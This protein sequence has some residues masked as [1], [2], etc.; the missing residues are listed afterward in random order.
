MVLKMLD[1]DGLKG[2]RNVIIYLENPNL[3]K[4]ASQ[5]SKLNKKGNRVDFI[6]RSF[7]NLNEDD[8]I[9]L[10]EYLKDKKEIL[11]EV[12]EAFHNYKDSDKKEEI[13]K[14]LNSIILKNN[15]KEIKKLCF[16]QICLN[17][18][19][20]CL[21]IVS[22]INIQKE[23]E[24]FCQICADLNAERG[25]I[26]GLINNVN[27]TIKETLK[28]NLLL[29]EI[30]N[31]QVGSEIPILKIVLEKHEPIDNL[32]SL[33][34][35]ELK[36]WNIEIIET[37]SKDIKILE[38][39]NI[40][41]KDEL[42]LI[43]K[44]N[45][46]FKSNNGHNIN[47]EI[48]KK[49]F[50]QYSSEWLI[51]L[52]LMYIEKDDREQRFSILL[53]EEVVNRKDIDGDSLKE[54]AKRIIK[55]IDKNKNLRNVLLKILIKLEISEG[56]DN[57]VKIIYTEGYSVLKNENLSDYLSK[58]IQETL[59]F[60]WLEKISI[61][62]EYIEPWNK[63][64]IKLLVFILKDKSPKYSYEIL[65]ILKDNNE[66]LF[67]NIMKEFEEIIA[68]K[69]DKNEK[70]I[71]LMI[72]F[73]YVCESKSALE[74]INKY[75]LEHEESLLV[76]MKQLD[77]NL[78]EKKYS[79]EINVFIKEKKYLKAIETINKIENEETKQSLTVSMINNLILSDFNTL[80]KLWEHFRLNIT[81]KTNLMDTMKEKYFKR[82]I[83]LTNEAINFADIIKIDSL[84]LYNLIDDEIQKEYLFKLWHKQGQV[85][86]I[87]EVIKGKIIN[88]KNDLDEINN[89]NDIMKKFHISDHKLIMLL[90]IK[91]YSL[92]SIKLLEIQGVDS[93]AF[94]L[95]NYIAGELS[96]Y[97]LVDRFISDEGL[98]NEIDS[99][100][101]DYI[102]KLLMERNTS[103]EFLKYYWD[104]ILATYNDSSLSKDKM[105]L[106]LEHLA[107]S[108]ENIEWFIDSVYRNNVP[109]EIY[110]DILETLLLLLN[111]GNRIKMQLNQEKENL[112]YEILGRIANNI[113]NALSNIE[114][115]IVNR[116]K[117]DK[118]DILFE[119]MKKIRSSLMEVGINTVEDIDNYGV[120]IKFDSTKHKNE[121]LG[122]GE[123]GIVD[124]LGVSINNKNILLGTLLNSD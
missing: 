105:D 115:V 30:N 51:K 98:H 110:N 89:I 63:L 2:L 60:K 106:F 116:L 108:K 28:Y 92:I 39:Y 121:Q 45:D 64:R 16:K 71:K 42:S 90:R 114:K 78:L 104:K 8:K 83:K 59:E 19:K 54:L 43:E 76:F 65:K 82:E 117:D 73:N 47:K 40:N 38:K 36:T 57:V 124:S 23:K 15:N 69:M 33:I 85:G 100:I 44:I 58:H 29:S 77:P 79:A 80:I 1:K 52:S 48:I 109:Q 75:K 53:L 103:K 10:I 27:V 13:S 113:C 56:F 120:M 3:I 31:I 81:S 102:I 97:N 46:N 49:F 68:N 32:I 18:G 50:E 101:V 91:A 74:E 24:E 9:V 12:I 123:T 70:I 55:I 62:N 87:T 96:L 111:K 122:N 37:L 84:K 6:A 67:K 94:E 25:Y 95:S 14:F 72:V 119:N 35:N 66:H 4:S 86:K 88:G 22:E 5:K 93:E 61:S 17:D 21:K 7:K 20:M 41:M 112:E 26:F 107:K 118:Y 34:N 99:R 11:V